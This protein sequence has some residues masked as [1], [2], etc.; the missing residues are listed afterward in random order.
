MATHLTEF[1][2]DHAAEIITR[3]DI[4][5]FIDYVRKDYPAVVD[6]VIP[7]SLTLS[8]F[9]KII[10]NLLKERIGQGYGLYFEAQDIPS[11]TKDLTF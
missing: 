3:Q 9:H 2:K 7:K 1:I 6:E 10:A 4:Q 11:K 8:E 5:G